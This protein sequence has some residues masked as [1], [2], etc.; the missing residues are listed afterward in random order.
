M[1]GTGG[2]RI[3]NT[4]YDVL[5]NF[6]GRGQSLAAACTAP[7]MHTEGDTR[8]QLAAGWP[9][10]EVAYLKRIGYSIQPG[11]GAKLNA[12]ARDPAAGT[13]SHVI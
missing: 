5:V 12:I 3:P 8:L 7:R 2:R 9:E 1:G 10:A 11:G 13:L 4:L 6:I